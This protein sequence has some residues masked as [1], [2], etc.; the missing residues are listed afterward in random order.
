MIDVTTDT[1]A[2][3]DSLQQLQ[4]RMGNL[5][6]VFSDLG[7]VLENKIRDRRET[8]TDPDGQRWAAWTP[9]TIASYPESGRGKLLDRSG[10]MWDRTGPQWMVSGMLFDT[11]LRV[12]FDKDYPTY[13]EFGTKHMARRGLLFADPEKGELG[14]ADEQ[15]IDDVL[16]DWLDG[17]F[18]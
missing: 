14:A 18:D 17:V 5:R 3:A 15:A 2:F 12:G 9:S 13:H 4:K 7:A 1:S 11:T 8:L 16:Q 6:P 10:D